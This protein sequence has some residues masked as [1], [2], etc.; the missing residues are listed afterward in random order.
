MLLLLQ[1]AASHD[2][3]LDDRLSDDGFALLPLARAAGAGAE[4]G[5]C[6]TEGERRV[7]DS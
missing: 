4:I 6:D 2:A 7:G 3:A 5:R 1:A